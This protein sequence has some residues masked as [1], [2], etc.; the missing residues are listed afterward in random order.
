M[1]FLELDLDESLGRA[2][3]KSNLLVRN[4][5]QKQLKTFG[6]TIDQW[7][8]LKTLYKHH[9]FDSAE[10]YNQKELAKECS[11]DQASLT[12]ILDIL[13][14]KDLLKRDKSSKDRREFLI[15]LT[16]EGKE[17][18]EKMLPTAQNIV[19]NLNHIYTE[20][21]MSILINLLNK[22]IVNLE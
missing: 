3:F 6:I 12:R 10:A 22:L 2:L 1:V 5:I 20:E 19:K 13:E 11:K 16:S 17:L 18:I 8:I 4:N 15:L 21:E 9:C 7:T 14:K